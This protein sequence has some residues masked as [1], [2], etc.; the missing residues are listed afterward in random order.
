VT[1]NKTVASV[2][3]LV[4][5]LVLGTAFGRDLLG[6]AGIPESCVRTIERASRAIDTGTALA[7]D[8]RAAL[9]A[10]RDVRVGDALDLLRDARDNAVALASQVQRFNTARVACNEDR[11]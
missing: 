1:G 4:I 5:G 3:T 10:V 8:G 9:T 6:A 2:V 11:E 7:D